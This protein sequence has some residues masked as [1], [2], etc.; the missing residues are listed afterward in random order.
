MIVN[1]AGYSISLTPSRSEPTQLVDGNELTIEHRFF[2]PSR[3]DPVD[4]RDLTIFQAATDHHRIIQALKVVYS[5]RW[6]TTGR[7]QRG[8]GCG[9]PSPFLPA[10][11]HGTIVYVAANDVVNQKD[12]YAAFLDRVGTDPDCRQRIRDFQRDALFVGAIVPLMQAAAA[13]QGL[14]VPIL[15]SAERAL[16]F[17]VIDWAFGLW[18]LGGQGFCALIPSSRCAHSRLVRRA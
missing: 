4:W 2:L 13:S 1:T 9:L 15:G 14:T 3:P 5:G 16:D 18:Q 10:N 6:L 17:H 11:V 12:G 8:N 7:R